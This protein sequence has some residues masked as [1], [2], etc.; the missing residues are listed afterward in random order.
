MKFYRHPELWET[1]ISNDNKINHPVI[2]N[3]IYPHFIIDWEVDYYNAL[4]NY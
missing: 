2:T 1:L 3:Q 4:S